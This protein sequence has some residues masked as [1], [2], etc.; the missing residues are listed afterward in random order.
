MEHFEQL[1]HN[2]SRHAASYEKAARCQAAAAETL[3]DLVTSHFAKPAPAIFDLGTGTGLLAKALLKRFPD[4]CL[5]GVDISA[6]MLECCAES[7]ELRSVIADG[8]F[9]FSVADISEVSVPQE[10]DLCVSGLTL[11][12]FEDLDGFLKRLEAELPPNALFAFSTLADGTFR[13]LHRCFEAVGCPY[14]GPKLKTGKALQTIVGEH[15][16]II[17]NRSGTWRETH[18][19]PRAFLRQVQQTGAV[20]AAGNPVPVSVLRHIIRD[21]ERRF[22]APDGT[23]EIT[24]ELQYFICRRFP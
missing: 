11:Q 20:N 13:D 24:Y 23:V 14:P 1:R 18:S 12:W 4:C 16:E 8:R 17:E 22:A 10:I 19:S 5:A 15:F 2:F 3:A 21:Y 7:A 9:H 6:A